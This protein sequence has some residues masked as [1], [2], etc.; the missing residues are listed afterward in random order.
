MEHAPTGRLLLRFPFP[1]RITW[2]AAVA[3]AVTGL[4]V[5][6]RTGGERKE[7]VSCTKKATN[8]GVKGV[9]KVGN[10]VKKKEKRPFL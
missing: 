3:A 7:N 5:V 8:K 4:F 1:R 10:G 2:A 6:A 9:E